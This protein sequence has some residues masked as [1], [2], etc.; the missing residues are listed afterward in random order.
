LAY[1]E[2]IDKIKL[3][4]RSQK[5]PKGPSGAV[6]RQLLRGVRQENMI[7]EICMIGMINYFRCKQRC[8]RAAFIPPSCV[9]S[10]SYFIMFSN[11]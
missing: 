1:A 5:E 10:V 3:C 7:D 4:K 6:L 11:D 8:G 9:S 2:T